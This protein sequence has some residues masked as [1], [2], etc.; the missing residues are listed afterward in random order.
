MVKVTESRPFGTDV[1]GNERAVPKLRSRGSKGVGDTS[2]FFRRSCRLWLLCGIAALGCF[3]SR[4]SPGMSL[5]STGYVVAVYDGD[6]IAL[7]SGQKVRY[8]GIDA[9]EVEHKD[10][11]GDCYGGEAKGFNRRQVL[12]RRIRL[13]Y[14]RESV[15][16]YG[17]LLAYVFLDD[18]RCIN[19]E[20]LRAGCAYVFRY[21]D[22]F[23]RQN[24]FLFWQR[25]AIENRE[26]M[27]GACQF[28]C[29]SYYVGN[30]ASF[31]FHSPKCRYGK[32]TA[33]KGR[34]RF[35]TRWKALEEGFRPCRHCRP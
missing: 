15:D 35:E 2:L 3:L 11:K 5:P 24:E 18:G 4:E 26:G 21:Y 34:R 27:W 31:V 33:G 10:R 32:M 7:E 29:F 19:A 23:S 12:H 1:Q 13:E 17:R 25:Q 22:G 28:E 8:L 30:K 6:T 16:R 9:P 14:D 20:M